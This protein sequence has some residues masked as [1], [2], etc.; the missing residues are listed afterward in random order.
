MRKESR[1]DGKPE[2]SPRPATN[3]TEIT[4]RRASSAGRLMCREKVSQCLQ[5]DNDQVQFLINTRQII[6]VRILG[7]E[8]F[9]SRDL[10]RLIDT[11][12][13]TAVRRAQ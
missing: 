1:G 8:R 6:A 12:K 13:A 3:A 2:S 7:E 5:L 4:A 10:E 11:Y 9:D